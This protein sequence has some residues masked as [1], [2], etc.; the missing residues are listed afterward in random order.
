MPFGAIDMFTAKKCWG[1]FLYIVVSYIVVQCSRELGH[2]NCVHCV[3]I[4]LYIVVAH[5]F[6]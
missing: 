6:Y 4:N 1:T 5:F 2:G 3:N